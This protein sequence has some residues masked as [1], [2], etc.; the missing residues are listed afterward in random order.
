MRENTNG[1]GGRGRSRFSTAESPMQGSIPGPQDDHDTNWRHTLQPTEPPTGP[2]A[3]FFSFLF[4]ER[5][6][7]RGGLS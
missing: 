3:F 4:T 2:E 1:G 6:S 5:L 7:L